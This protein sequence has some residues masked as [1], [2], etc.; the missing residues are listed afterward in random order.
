[1][2]LRRPPSYAQLQH[3]PAGQHT[4]RIQLLLC[5]SSSRP[6]GLAPPSVDP[7]VFCICMFIYSC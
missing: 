6:Q 5:P 4:P 2:S 3:S 1:M 7:R